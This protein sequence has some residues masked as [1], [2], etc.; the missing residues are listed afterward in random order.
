VLQNAHVANEDPIR[1]QF[2][3]PPIACF[4]IPLERPRPM[5]AIGHFEIRLA[6]DAL[7]WR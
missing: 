7:N 3:S 2:Q 1:G 4:V 5:N 6:L